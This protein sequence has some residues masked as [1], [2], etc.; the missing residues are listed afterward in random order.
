MKTI[1]TIFRITLMVWLLLGAS[2]PVYKLAGEGVCK[3]EFMESWA[4]Y[5]TSNGTA[6]AIFALPMLIGFPLTLVLAVV[7]FL[8][9]CALMFCFAE[10]AYTFILWVCFGEWHWPQH[11]IIGEFFRK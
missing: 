7:F 1:K 8:L 11:G 4:N 5:V 3:I 2:I 10:T 6:G 9:V